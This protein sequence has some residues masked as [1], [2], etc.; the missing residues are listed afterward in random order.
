[1]NT[2]D[3]DAALQILRDIHIEAAG[4]RA[5]KDW[6]EAAM[7]G[8][9]VLAKRQ[10]HLTSDDVWAWVRP[11][12]IRTTDSRAMGAV[13]RNCFRDRYIEPTREFT[14]SERPACHKR[15]IRIWKSLTYES[16]E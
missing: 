2:I 4:R 11:L 8:V 9:R 10:Q 1:M 5:D 7:R 15:P 14:P 6:F 3:R 13:M 12:G 16:D